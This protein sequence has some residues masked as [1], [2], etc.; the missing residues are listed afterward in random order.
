VKWSFSLR[1]PTEIYQ[2]M[3]LNSLSQKQ[4][5]FVIDDNEAVR[6][7]IA[8]LVD[9]RGLPVETFASGE[10]FCSRSTQALHQVVSSPTCA[11]STE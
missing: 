4:T 6:E 7:S 8:A 9:I 1:N 3:Q 11:W 2:Q 10:N 5:V